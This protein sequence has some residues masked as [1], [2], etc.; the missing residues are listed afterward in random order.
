MSAI[1]TDAVH[2]A[3]KPSTQTSTHARFEQSLPTLLSVIA[4][5]VDLTGLVNFHLFTAHITGNLVMVSAL[6][7]R[8]SHV[9]QAQFLAI[10]VFVVAVAVT[11]LI[12]KA[13]GSRGPRLLRLLLVAQFL[14]L[15]CVLI[16][17]VI[18]KPSTNPNAL[19]GTIAAMIAVSAMACQFAL[20][21][22]TM[23]VAPTTA[24]MTGNLTTT[25]LFLFDA[26][27][28]SQLLMMRDTEKLR[29]TTHLLIGFLVGCLLSAV[30]IGF[31]GHEWAWAVPA[32]A[33]AMAMFLS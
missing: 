1:T 2:V 9:S 31:L 26:S 21:R 10:P 3:S 5:M 15:V 28:H 16:V 22:L 32:V 8:G 25:F 14:L 6:L 23:P 19:M 11:W 7:V 13:S 18:T 12:A 30:A 33:S 20:L 4:G 17:S 29:G 24:V 27:A